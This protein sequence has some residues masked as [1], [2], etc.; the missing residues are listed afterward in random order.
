MREGKRASA[1]A[2]V[3]FALPQ[4]VCTY[5][6]GSLTWYCSVLAEAIH[7]MMVCLSRL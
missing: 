2:R 6:M 3:I 1:C 4:I 7:L 5:F